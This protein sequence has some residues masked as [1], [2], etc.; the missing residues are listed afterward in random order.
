MAGGEQS[1][2][3]DGLPPEF[4]RGRSYRSG[5]NALFFEMPDKTQ[6]LRFCKDGVEDLLEHSDECAMSLERGFAHGIKVGMTG[7]PGPGGFGNSNPASRGCCWRGAGLERRSMK[8]SD[9]FEKESWES[10]LA[11]IEKRMFSI[12][13]LMNCNNH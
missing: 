1:E 3:K 2:S 4:G 12:H 13:I 11:T 10:H 6:P 7:S 5:E 9:S 8:T